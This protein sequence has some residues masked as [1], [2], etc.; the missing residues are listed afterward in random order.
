[1][2]NAKLIENF[3]EEQQVDIEPMLR[4]RQEELV[5]VIEAIDSISQS[6]YWKLLEKKL[7]DPELNSFINQLCN[8]K[9]NQKMSWLQG[10]IAILSKYADF[11]KLSESHRLKLQQIKEQL[12]GRE[13]K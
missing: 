13:N 8:E 10:A 4:K 5:E 7:F 11:R 6:D 12:Q 1:M 2:N 3:P 9:D